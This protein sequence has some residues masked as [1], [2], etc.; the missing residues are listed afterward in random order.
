MGLGAF[1]KPTAM[2]PKQRRTEI[3]RLLSRLNDHNREIFNRMYS[4]ND[5]HQDVNDT[6]DSMP[7]KKLPWALTQCQNSYYSLFKIIKHSTE[8]N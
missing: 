8:S 4:P 7:A 1:R 6:V 3:K 5:I 2:T